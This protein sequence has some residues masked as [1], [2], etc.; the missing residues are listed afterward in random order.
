MAGRT[1]KKIDTSVTDVC[2]VRFVRKRGRLTS[3]KGLELVE[4]TRPIRSEK[5]GQTS[6]GKNFPASLAFGAIIGLVVGMPNPLDLRCAPGARLSI[7]PVNRHVLAKG[8]DLLRKSVL[9]LIAQLVHPP[10]KS[11]ARCREQPFPLFRIE[12]LRMSDR[13]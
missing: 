7:P 13:R 11:V 5:S 9:G 10:S 1:P 6:I 3:S 4:C 2:E 12:P 8:S